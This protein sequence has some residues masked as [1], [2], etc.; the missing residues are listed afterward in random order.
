MKI[1]G[2][3][4]FLVKE[5]GI[6]R[7]FIFLK[8]STDE[9]IEGIGEAYPTGKAKATETVLHDY[10]R[11]L[12]GKDP[13]RVVY[14]WQALYR[15]SR[16]P[17]G[18]ITMGALSGVEL[19]LWDIIGKRYG[20][21]IYKLLGGPC[22]DKIRA[23]THLQGSTPEELAEEAR[24]LVKK[25]YTAMKF[26]PYPPDYC[27]LGPNAIVKRAVERVRA[28]REAVGDD[29]DI[30]L[31]YHGTEFSAANAARMAKALEP[32]QPLFLEEP[33]LHENVDAMLEVKNKTTIPIATGER[34]FTRYGFRELLD[35]RAVDI[36]QP[37]PIACGGIL[38]TLRIG[39]MAEAYYVSLA[40]H[41]PCGPV[42]TAGC[43]H[44][45]ACAPNFLIQ[46]HIPDDS[47]FRGSLV[48]EPMKLERGYFHLP[49]RPGLGIELDEEGLARYP[50]EPYDRRVAIR[51]DGSIG[52]V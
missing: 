9:G 13:T 36:I 17:L 16:F 21:P 18:T 25:G 45:D 10:E 42:A 47:P 5:N 34:L 22:R 51:E 40:P 11:W 38:E 6:G 52:L 8:I 28:V 23:Y 44:V 29:V 32:F 2:L 37:D 31:D 19:A 41:N 15:G 26:V 48:D 24:V 39:A 14:H 35:K 49:T 4:T 27:T 30:L 12:A 43:L 33:V 1:T 20:A 46:E 3:K 7:N 50:F